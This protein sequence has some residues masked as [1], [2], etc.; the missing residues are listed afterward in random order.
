VI[1]FIV[2]AQIE[3]NADETQTLVL[4]RARRDRPSQCAAQ[5]RDKLAPSHRPPYLDWQNG[6]LTI[7]HPIAGG[8]GVAALEEGALPPENRLFVS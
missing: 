8:T 7:P 5:P 3:K 2:L 4:L 6:G 1:F